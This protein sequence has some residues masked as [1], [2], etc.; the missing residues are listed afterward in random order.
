MGTLDCKWSMA[1]LAAYSLRWIRWK[2][3]VLK[4]VRSNPAQ[5][6]VI[7]GTHTVTQLLRQIYWHSPAHGADAVVAL[8]IMSLSS[9]GWCQ[10]HRILRFFEGISVDIEFGHFP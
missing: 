2:I 7:Q 9:F 6:G 5:C 10:E 8:Y 3:I 1:T 4:V